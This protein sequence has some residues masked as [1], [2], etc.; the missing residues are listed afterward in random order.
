MVVFI[1]QIR[2]VFL[3][4]VHAQSAASSPCF[5]RAGNSL[6][7]F[8]IFVKLT[9]LTKC[10][11]WRGK[12]LTEAVAQSTLLLVASEQ[13]V[14]PVSFK[15]AAHTVAA[16]RLR[17]RR[18]ET[19]FAGMAIRLRKNRPAQTGTGRQVGVRKRELGAIR[20]IHSLP[21]GNSLAG[22]AAGWKSIIISLVLCAIALET[23]FFVWN[24]LAENF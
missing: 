3:S 8:A 23:L 1:S 5:A 7:L 17:V 19:R 9:G 10:P 21:Q 6:P 2:P 24:M 13:K 4:L 20:C 11:S 15:P 22:C 18:D 16:H 14:I 12:P